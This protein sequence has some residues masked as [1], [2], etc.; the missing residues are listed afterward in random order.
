MHGETMKKERY[1]WNFSRYFNICIYSTISPG[2]LSDVLPNPGRAIPMCTLR[3][4]AEPHKG[5]C[6]IPVLCLHCYKHGD[7]CRVGNANVVWDYKES[8]HPW[9]RA[10]EVCSETRCCINWRWFI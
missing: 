6:E 5:V 2:I 10:H 3:V 1:I 4:Y 8:R 7:G 9:K